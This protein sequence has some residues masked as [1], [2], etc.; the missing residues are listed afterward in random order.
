MLNKIKS[1]IYIREYLEGLDQITNHWPKESVLETAY[2]GMSKAGNKEINMLPQNCSYALEE[3][4][5][6]KQRTQKQ[7]Q[8]KTKKPTTIGPR[9]AATHLRN[10]P[11]I[12]REQGNV[13]FGS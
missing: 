11:K 10:A 13:Y 9:A 5:S 8:K 7:K 4:T 1:H 2:T 3:P 12:C 6:Q